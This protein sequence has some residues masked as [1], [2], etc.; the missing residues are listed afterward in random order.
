ME[1]VRSLLD[2]VAIH[3]TENITN[4]NILLSSAN[5]DHAV[6]HSRIEFVTQHTV[7]LNFTQ[8]YGARRYQPLSSAP[9]KQTSQ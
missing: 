5:S 6:C 8:R 9:Q 7:G 2:L 3:A 1:T 4:L